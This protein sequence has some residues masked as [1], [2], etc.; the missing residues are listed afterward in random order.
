[1]TDSPKQAPQAEE[2]LEQLQVEKVLEESR[3]Q[4]EELLQNPDK[5]ERFLQR[6]EK[7]LGVV[8]VVGGILSNI[9]RMASMVRSYTSKEYPDIP[10]GTILSVLGALLYF[11]SPIDL[12][13]DSIPGVG[14]IDDSVVIAVCLKLAGSDLQEYAL[15]REKKGKVFEDIPDFPSDIRLKQQIRRKKKPGGAGKE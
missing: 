12:L 15:W 8:P 3:E 1:V 10:I 7:K 11:V 5:L 14:Y 13:P 6:L 4:A 9:P 2:E